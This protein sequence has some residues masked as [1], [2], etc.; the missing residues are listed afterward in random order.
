MKSPVIETY[1]THQNKMMPLSQNSGY[2]LIYVLKNV[3]F[4][5]YSLSSL[6]NKSIFK[7]IK[8]VVQKFIIS[9]KFTLVGLNILLRGEFVRICDN[10]KEREKAP[11]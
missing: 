2:W 8:K 1:T 9:L 7:N 3:L 5:F 6:F 4:F 10:E 11:K